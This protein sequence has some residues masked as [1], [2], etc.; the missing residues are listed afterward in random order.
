MHRPV[1]TPTITRHHVASPAGGLSA[2]VLRPAGLSGLPPLVALHGISRN[3]DELVDLF[4]PAAER[5]GRIVIVPHFPQAQWP[6]FQRPCRAARPDRALLALLSHLAAIDGALAAPVD[7]FGHS[8]GA[9]LAHRFAML[10]PHKVGRLHLA[11]AGWYCL[12]DT[13]MAHPYGLGADATPGSLTWARCH[14]QALPSFL[15]LPVQVYVGTADDARDASLRQTPELDRIQ[16][17]TRIAR[18]RTYVD[19]FRAAARARGIAP[20]ITLTLLP[21]IVHDVAHAIRHGNLAARVTEGPDAPFAT[22]L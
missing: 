7:L 5:S 10:Y 15:R 12:P 13:G 8:G 16:G 6:H 11:A 1:F 2:R 20:D 14:D 21:G 9:Q 17:L 22:A 18:A 4:L 19:R 3:A